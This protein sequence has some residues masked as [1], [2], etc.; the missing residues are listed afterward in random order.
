MYGIFE[1]YKNACLSLKKEV[2]RTISQSVPGIN[3][4]N[5]YHV[6]LL[7]AQERQ[8][9]RYHPLLRIHCRSLVLNCWHWGYS[10]ALH[11]GILGHSF[12]L[13]LEGMAVRE[14]CLS[15]ATCAV[16]CYTQVDRLPTVTV[17][18]VYNSSCPFPYVKV[19]H[20]W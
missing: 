3:E 2:N 6:D 16:V 8:F 9:S 4:K 12:W 10:Q 5:T 19:L 13:A 11:S 1:R 20:K 15:L 18:L 14:G 17:S 7:V